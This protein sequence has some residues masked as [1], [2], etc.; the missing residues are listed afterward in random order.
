MIGWLFVVLTGC[1]SLGCFDTGV[2]VLVGTHSLF[3]SL[4]LCFGF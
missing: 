1:W 3:G 4:L 2:R